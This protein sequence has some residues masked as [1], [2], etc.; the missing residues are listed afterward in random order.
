MTEVLNAFHWKGQPSIFVT[1]DFNGV[2]YTRSKS[3]SE[4]TNRSTPLLPGSTPDNKPTPI[5]KAKKGKNGNPDS[6]Q[7]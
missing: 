3:S 5:K 1:N 4:H 6:Y 7:P 2:N